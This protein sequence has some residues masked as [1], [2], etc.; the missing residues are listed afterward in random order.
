MD[1]VDHRESGNKLDLR[2][3]RSASNAMQS[4]KVRRASSP[5][6]RF[7]GGIGLATTV[8]LFLQLLVNLSVFGSFP[9]LAAFLS[10]E[11]HLSAGDIASVLTVSLL[12]SRLLPLI[13]GFATDRFNSRVLASSGLACR[14]MG[15][16]GLGHVLDF[17]ALLACAFLSGLGA[18]LY[19]TTAYSVFGSLKTD[20]RSRVF[21]LNNLVLNLGALVGPMVLFLLP[22]HGGAFPFEVSGYIF[23]VLALV[24]PFAA[25]R[26]HGH[27]RP[28]RVASALFE[29]FH[30]R[31]FRRL[32]IALI[33]FWA[34]YTQIY[35][36]IPLTFAQGASG[37]NGVRPFY[38]ANALF[39]V[40]TALLGM[41]WFQ[42]ARWQSLMSIGHLALLACFALAA[43]IFLGEW[44]SQQSLL[45]LVGIALVFTFGESLI[46]PAS[47]IALAE[48]TT[49]S[50]AGSYFGAS[51]VS[52]A[53]GGALGNY[54][55]SMGA[56]WTPISMGWLV[57]AF[58][59]MI[60]LLCF[61]RLER[62][63]A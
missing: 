43:L 12:S 40:L 17:P 44:N 46:L 30:D 36:F 13:L 6:D 26:T 55:G 14:A 47:N 15:F 16:I 31:Q 3:I 20:I 27:E 18:A 39:G 45:I 50:N 52:W 35:V 10:V 53:I 33:P 21:V 11:Q 58:V 60:G 42:R 2:R 29:V 54:L 34:V 9:L 25:V 7:T 24:A 8:L 63:P 57:F 1:D 23:A 41:R 32:C 61:K 62:T 22:A 28:R 37:Y 59:S 19:E 48:L 5:F 51:A 38:I 4:M 49:E 56:R